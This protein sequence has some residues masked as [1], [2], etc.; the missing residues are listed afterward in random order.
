MNAWDHTA[1]ARAVAVAAM[2]V[3]GG[4]GR[5]AT[6]QTAA[7]VPPPR[8]IADIT[9][10]LDQEKPDAAKLAKL[11]AEADATP[12]KSAAGLAEFLYSRAQARAALGRTRE[13]TADAEAAVGASR[14]A[15]YV[16][17]V[18]RYE[19]YLIRLLRVAGEHR[20]AIELMNRQMRNFENKNRGRLF[21][22]NL[23]M[24]ISYLNLSD[25]PRAE[26]YLQRNR[27]LL[28]ESRKW[29]NFGVYAS[30]W[31]AQVEDGNGRIF[32]AH[33]RFADAEKAYHR[34]AD[35]YRDALTRVP[36]YQTPPP[37]GA[38]ENAIDWDTAF[39]GRVK[40]KQGRVAEGEVDVRR[41]L[42][43]RLSLVGKYHPDTAGILGILAWVLGEQGRNVEAEQLVRTIIEI[44]RGMNFPDDS[45][46]AVGARVQLATVLNAQRRFDDAAKVYQEV[47]RLVSNWEPSRRD[48]VGSNLARVSVML[49]TGSPTDALQ[50]AKNTLEREKARSGETSFGT[51]LARGF[52]AMSLARANRAGEAVVEFRAAIPPL[53]SASRQSVDE[54]GATA[55]ARETRVRIVIESYLALLARAPELAGGDVGEET[56]GLADVV[57]GHAVERALAASSLR[58]AAKDPLL[59]DLVRKG[60]DLKKQISAEIGTLN[61]LLA[62]PPDERDQA[63]LKS[64]QDLITKLQA[65]EAAARKDVLRR[66]PDYANLIDPPPVTSSELR[67]ALRDEEVLLS[68]YFGRQNG[69]VWAL[70][71]SGPIRFARLDMTARQLDTK[72]SKLRDA[73]E[74][75]ATTIADVPTFDIAAAHDLFKQ[76]LEPVQDGWRDAKNLIVVTN[77]ALGL[78]PLSLLPTAPAEVKRDDDPPFSSYRAV[79]WLAR[80]HAVTMVPSASAL[81]TLRRSPPGKATREPLI[82]FGDPVFNREQATETPS[83]AVDVAE[84]TVVSRGVP[85]KRR[86]S[87]QLDDKTSASL[88]ML[89]RLPDTAEELKSISLALEADPAKALFLG[90]DA[91]ERKVKSTDLSKFKIIAFAT[92]G[93]VPGEIDGLTQSALALSAPDVA[94]VDGDGLLTMEEILGLRLDADWVVLSACNT[95]TGAG[96]GAEAAS[97][98]GRAFFYAGTRALLVTNWSVHSQSARELTSDLFRRQAADPKLTRGEALRQAM[99]GLV[100]GPGYQD[101]QG[102]TLFTYAHPLFWAP[103]TII[104]DGG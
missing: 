13:A 58:A 51:A 24:M 9:A 36:Q 50:M 54:D 92:H 78:L 37:R 53:L 97:G 8:T 76:L 87:P 3:L 63:A 4:S 33:G 26:S 21:N 23:M 2:L 55:V 25:V 43:G 34:S 74:P 28:A 38:L 52:V 62:L 14:G 10:I 47:D 101:E 56:F 1:L 29:Q 102:R 18:S 20:R 41:A 72:I 17:E 48:A 73:L 80:T 19:N 85:L 30:N 6:A 94:G 70:R 84:A 16:D 22:L 46:P 96:A 45:P 71:K 93:L 68:F 27:A 104:G 89:P 90:K 7:L 32:E 86:S 82:A 100:D 65:S 79:P 69:F 12:P 83:T 95:G 91:N 64:S 44:Y 66:F 103:Y 61:N 75:Q 98:L 77:G 81:R 60:Q 67:T 88:A 57:R 39:E 15:D 31:N 35:L 40:A 5:L 59:A 42:L 49:G 11:A 99:M